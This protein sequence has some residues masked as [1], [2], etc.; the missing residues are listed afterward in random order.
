MCECLDEKLIKIVINNLV[1]CSLRRKS[2]KSRTV[3]KMDEDA[4]MKMV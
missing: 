4:V 2:K 1:N 3:N